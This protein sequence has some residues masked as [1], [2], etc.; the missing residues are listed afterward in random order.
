MSQV[1]KKKVM[2]TLEPV[3]DSVFIFKSTINM[4]AFLFCFSHPPFF[5]PFNNLMDFLSSSAFHSH[6]ILIIFLSPP[7]HLHHHLLSS[8]LTYHLSL[9]RPPP[10]RRR[11][12]LLLLL[13][14]SSRVLFS[15]QCVCRESGKRE[16]INNTGKQTTC[17]LLRSR[18][19]KCADRNR[20]GQPCSRIRKDGTDSGRKITDLHSS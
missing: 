19:V 12:H 1:L 9:H 5:S 7:P 20:N 17:F 3:R 10:H 6:L 2:K 18:V 11:R 13:L 4:D 15:L 8:P 14:V 16:G